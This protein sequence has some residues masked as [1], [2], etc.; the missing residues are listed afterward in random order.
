MLYSYTY[1]V[2]YLLLLSLFILLTVVE[3]NYDNNR[4]IRQCVRICCCALF[5]LFFG[6]RGFVGW[7]WMNY[8]PA[9]QEI[10][11]LFS[12][13]YLNNYDI[14]TFEG[15]F[16]TFMSVVKLISSNYHFFIL[17]C[18]VI[19]VSI[20]HVFFKRY[21]SN[22]AF[23]FVIFMALYL[24]SEV[25]I[26][27]NMKS[28]GLFLLS[29][30]YIQQRRFLPYLF[31]MILA[32]SFHSSTLFLFPLYFIP[33]V[34]PRRWFIAIFLIGNLIYFSQIAYMAP[35]ISGLGGLLGGKYAILTQI[36]LSLDLFAQ[37]RG[38]SIGYLERALTFI[39]VVLFY[40]KLNTREHA[41][42]LNMFL[43]Y[44]S[45]SLFV[46]EITIVMDR[47]GLLF[48]LSYLVLWPA[49]TRCFTLK[50]NRILFVG[51]IMIYSVIRV[52]IC[53][54]NILYRYDNILLSEDSYQERAYIL[55]KCRDDLI[56]SN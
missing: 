42:F 55:E 31:L 47:I 12:R 10:V 37:A 32:F 48:L 38:I 56:N 13:D 35:V 40:K 34:F 19:D 15:G 44:L 18:V 52:A 51:G 39:L 26:L 4:K 28:I 27:R 41:I 1:S 22:Y 46:S 11:P 30:K 2:P 33:R 36:Y 3:Y 43:I 5:V 29:I 49:I 6:F 50:P 14:G 53:S 8:Y 9:Y 17:V 16:I 20:L 25:E 21:S 7:D 54:N 23:S 45:I 24:G